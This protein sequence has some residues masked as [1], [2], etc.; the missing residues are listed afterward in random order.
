[1]KHMYTAFFG[2]LLVLG[3]AGVQSTPAYAG[4]YRYDPACNCN[5]PE[6]EYASRRV[7][8]GA[9]RV[10]TR[11]RVIDHTRVVPGQRRVI[12]ENHLVIHE[13]PVINRTVVV[14]RQNTV[15]K[16]IVVRRRNITRKSREVP[17]G[18]QV[19]HRYVQG[20]TR[21]VTEHV[22]VRGRDCDCEGTGGAYREATYRY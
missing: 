12:N 14:H 1:M 22:N 10:V 18:N 2:A 11:Q 8:R 6:S 17:G 5:R 21:R 16:D 4:G 3:L 20:E 7:V 9:P 15:V 13:R 19:V